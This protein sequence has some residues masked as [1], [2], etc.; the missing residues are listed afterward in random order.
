MFVEGPR[1]S[2]A[3]GET[4]TYHMEDGPTTLLPTQSPWPLSW[5]GEPG[6]VAIEIKDVP[7]DVEYARIEALFPEAFILCGAAEPHQD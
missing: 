1:V 4:R 2:L 7:S 5:F 6:Y 3:T